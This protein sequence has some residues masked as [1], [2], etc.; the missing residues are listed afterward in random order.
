[1]KTTTL[2]AMFAAIVLSGCKITES[3]HGIHFSNAQAKAD[4]EA[5]QSAIDQTALILIQYTNSA[6][7]LM[8]HP[9][10]S[11]AK[12]DIDQL[13]KHTLGDLENVDISECPDDFRVAYTKFCQGFRAL[14]M[15]IESI[16]GWNGA[17]KGLCNPTK[18]FTLSDDTDKAG[19]PFLDAFDELELVCGRYNVKV[20]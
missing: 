7:L 1:M 16:S 20:Q 12:N 9:M 17:L 19:K 5:V 2:L 8:Q 13:M 14:Q 3:S 11:I 15:Y 4:H 6:A 18:L 10:E